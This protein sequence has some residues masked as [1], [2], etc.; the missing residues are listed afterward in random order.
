[1]N[2]GII[3]LICLI[4]LIAIGFWRKLNVG[5]LAIAVAVMLG[6]GSGEYNTAKIVAGYS[7]SL[8]LT[9]FGL[10]MLFGIVTYNGCL[11]QILRRLINL[12]GRFMWFVPI[13][14]FVSAWLVSALAGAFAGMAFIAG[15]TIPVIH[16]TGYNPV[17]LMIIGNAG[18]QAGR[19][20]VF[21]PD[22]NIVLNLFVQQGL[23]ANLTA[24]TIN[25]T[26]A[27]GI[28]AVLAY[29]YFKGY[30]TRSSSKKLHLEIQKLTGKQW[31]TIVALI[32]MV[33]AIM[34]QGRDAGLMGVTISVA[35]ISSGVIDEKTAFQSVPWSTLIMV[36]GV[37]VLMKIV[38]NSGGIAI[39]THM[40]SSITNPFTAPGASC[41]MA[42]IMSWFSSTIGVV[43]PTLTP[44]VGELVASIGG[45]LTEMG[46]MSAML[47]G[48]SSACFSPASAVG[49]LIL[50]SIA[51]DPRLNASFNNE[52]AF[53]LMF[54]W[55]VAMLLI[56]SLLALSGLYS[57][58]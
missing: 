48:A 30:R 41:L 38:I 54:A 25:M 12:F 17:M 7:A 9:L 50:S 45:G 51:S 43:V 46:L 26:L 8:F 52:K 55:S 58:S 11:E 40:I 16:A 2:L 23:A 32:V 5:I 56:N 33:F 15:I 42:G 29:L 24:L 47:I 13:I 31:I 39:L 28:I 49:G 6:Y 27:M 35:L 37:G 21:S 57:F 10:T 34:V 44:T 20:T 36:T 14:L 19:Y 1:M 22:G 4:A 18:A 3:A 53:A